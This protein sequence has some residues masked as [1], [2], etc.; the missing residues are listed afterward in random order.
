[1]ALIGAHP[2]AEIILEV[3]SVA[4]VIG[5]KHRKMSSAFICRLRVTVLY[6]VKEYLSDGYT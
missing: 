4:L 2:K 3:Y 5:L 6:N 1:M